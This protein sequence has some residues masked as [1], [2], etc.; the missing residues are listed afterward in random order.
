MV[1]HCR[2]L[3]NVGGCAVQLGYCRSHSCRR[4]VDPFILVLVVLTMLAG[5]FGDIV[6]GAV[7]GSVAT[8]ACLP[9]L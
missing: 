7:A 8:Q 3:S 1:F 9:R 4:E 2:A 6:A 5:M